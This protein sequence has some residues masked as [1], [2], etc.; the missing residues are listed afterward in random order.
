MRVVVW[1]AVLAVW[2]GQVL[3]AEPI[4]ARIDAAKAAHARGDLAR[5]SAELE[6]VVAE[7]HA[8]MGKA[9]ADFLPPPLATWKAEPPE[10]QAL[11][12][13]GGGLSVSRAY[14]R[15]EASLNAT[16]ILDNPVVV[17]AAPQFAANAPEQPNTRRIKLGPDD[18]LL[19]WDA[20]NRSG[21]LTLLLGGRVLLQIEGESLGTAEQ[22]VEAAKGWNLS[23]LRKYL[24]L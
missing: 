17:G 19:R 5:A 7:L 18:A 6:S 22:L 24:G 21:D 10:I 3:A 1:A 16:L 9:L 15:D 23:G 12:G 2:A 13:A 11:G 20:A 14:G 4:P 8:R